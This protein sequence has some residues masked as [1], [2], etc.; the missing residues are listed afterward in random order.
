MTRFYLVF[1]FVAFFLIYS[2]ILKYFQEFSFTPDEFNL[3][4]LS[5]DAKQFGGLILTVMEA[6]QLEL[7]RKTFVLN[8]FSIAAFTVGLF[9][10]LL[11]IARSFDDTSKLYK[12]AYFL[13]ILPLL[14]AFFDIGPSIFMIA[15]SDAT[16]ANFPTWLA[17]IMSSG[18]VIRV[19]VLYFLV[20]WFL[21][22]LIRFILK[23]IKSK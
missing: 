10:L 2:S 4:W 16:L 9:A 6:D 23:T 20:F 19:L 14:I 3:V 1:G 8:I 7:F 21:F 15:V 18:Y 13:P 12:F 5:F 22:A 11:I 17:Y